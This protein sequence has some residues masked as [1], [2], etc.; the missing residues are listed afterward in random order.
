[1]VLFITALTFLTAALPLI[2]FKGTIEV[3]RAGFF[4]GGF[5]AFV[6]FVLWELWMNNIEKTTKALEREFTYNRFPDFASG[7][8]IADLAP[9]EETLVIRGG[10]GGSNAMDAAAA[11]AAERYARARRVGRKL[12]EF[13]RRCLP[14]I[15]TSLLGRRLLVGYF[16][17]FSGTFAVVMGSSVLAGQHA[18][19]YHFVN[20]LEETSDISKLSESITV[21][22]ALVAAFLLQSTKRYKWFVVFGFVVMLGGLMSMYGA[23]IIGKASFSSSIIYLP[24][25][26]L[27]IGAGMTFIPLLVGVQ[28]SC[29]TRTDVAIATG[30]LTTFN[31]LGALVADAVRTKV[32]VEMVY[33]RLNQEST[34]EDT[35]GV[36]VRAWNVLLVVAA[37]AAGSGLAVASLWLDNLRLDSV[38]KNVSGVVFGVGDAVIV[39]GSNSSDEEQ[40]EERSRGENLE[41]GD[42]ES[43][44]GGSSP[45]GS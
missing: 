17:G 5:S 15:R 25:Y 42:R 19:Y 16:V 14:L 21:A 23:Q 37:V 3:L 33:D 2:V 45:S 11:R 41:A 28:A 31:A 34:M 9:E 40:E 6:L 39:S 26:I 12:Q 29:V 13:K 4:F 20:G 32:G 1:M 24:Q 27:A 38:R 8:I 22:T 10:N 7:N 36:L 43:D 30:L 18:S 35:V 44:G